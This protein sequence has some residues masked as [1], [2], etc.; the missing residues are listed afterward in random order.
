MTLVQGAKNVLLCR[1][2][3]EDAFR[4]NPIDLVRDEM[5]LQVEARIEPADQRRLKVRAVDYLL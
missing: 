4:Y 1:P 2:L 3:L 5:R